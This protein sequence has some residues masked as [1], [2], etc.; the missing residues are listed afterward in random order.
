MCRG[1]NITLPWELYFDVSQGGRIEVE[2]ATASLSWILLS[3]QL[4]D[5]H[6]TDNTQRSKV[7][8]REELQAH[9]FVMPP[10]RKS[11]LVAYQVHALAMPTV[12]LESSA[13][14]CDADFKCRYAGKS[15]LRQ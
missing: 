2:F 11:D 1:A 10:E 3:M 9:C 6:G 14:P 7:C 4:L 15:R 13:S 12:S 5:N 8:P